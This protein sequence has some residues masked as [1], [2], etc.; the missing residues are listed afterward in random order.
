M[1]EAYLLLD[2][3]TVFEGRPFGY[4]G[5]AV[6]EL[7]FSTAM[8]GYLEALSDPAYH[9][10][11]LLQTF[12]LIGNYGVIPRDFGSGPIHL[13]AYIV[14]QWCQE[15]SNFRSEG[16]L[17]S[18]LRERGI[19]GLY[20][21]D[22]RALTRIIRENGTMNAMISTCPELCEDRLAS[23]RGYRVAGAVAAVEATE[24][25]D[26]DASLLTKG[27]AA[28]AGFKGAGKLETLG[29]STESKSEEQAD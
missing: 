26:P 27:L 13:K 16:N 18:F 7:V 5:E 20:G 1:G 14:R 2:N 9:G 23:L 4:I 29:Q 6:G 11:I 25:L 3:G 10:Q 28:V 8:T 17:D 21:I 19:P 12:P 15:P 24:K 22:T